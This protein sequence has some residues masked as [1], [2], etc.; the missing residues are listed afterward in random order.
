MLTKYFQCKHIN[1]HFGIPARSWKN[2][3][4][5]QNQT[6]FEY[7]IFSYFFCCFCLFYNFHNF[8]K[9]NELFFSPLHGKF[10]NPKSHFREFDTSL[11]RMMIKKV[12]CLGN[13]RRLEHDSIF[14]KHQK[15]HRSEWVELRWCQLLEFSSEMIFIMY[16]WCSLVGCCELFSSQLNFWKIFHTNLLAT[17]HSTRLSTV[18]RL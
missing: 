17:H 5:L 6:H 18:F 12:S 15:H 14:F 7:E 2:L 16:I 11:P 4:N 9:L 8:H 10:S 1:P 13:E 3:K